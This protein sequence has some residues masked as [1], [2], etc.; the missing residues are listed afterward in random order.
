MNPFLISKGA[1]SAISFLQRL[2]LLNLKL[3]RLNLLNLFVLE[4]EAP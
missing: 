4:L 2:V 3:M 1:A